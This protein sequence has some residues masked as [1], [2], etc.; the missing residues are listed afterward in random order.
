[1][2][3][4]GPILS[5]MTVGIYRH[6]VQGLG[7]MAKEASRKGAVIY[8]QLSGGNPVTSRRLSAGIVGCHY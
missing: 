7:S 5:V 8:G 3:F 4:R 2:F 6:P 1:M